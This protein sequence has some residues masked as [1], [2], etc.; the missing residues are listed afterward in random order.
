MCQCQCQCQSVNQKVI[1]NP[2]QLGFQWPIHTLSE[3]YRD[4]YMTGIAWDANWM[5]G[6]PYVHSVRP[7]LNPPKPERVKMAEDSQRAHDEWKEGFKRGLDERLKNNDHFA[8]WWDDNKSR[9]HLR[10]VDPHN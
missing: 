7:G 10:Y 6:G 8:Q 2:D 1:K 5:P 4:G 3:S 9:G